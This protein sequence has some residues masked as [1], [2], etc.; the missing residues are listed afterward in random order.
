MKLSGGSRPTR[1]MDTSSNK[2]I[3][4]C[5]FSPSDIRQVILYYAIVIPMTKFSKIGGQQDDRVVY[6]G[7]CSEGF[8]IIILPGMDGQRE[9]CCSV[10]DF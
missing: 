9:V 8:F 5:D 1:N 10:A 7:I 6:G 4:L 2:Y 3:L